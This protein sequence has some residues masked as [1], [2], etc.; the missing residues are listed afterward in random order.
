MRSF[1]AALLCQ[2]GW[3]SCA[4][5]AFAQADAPAQP[6]AVS[7]SR[8]VLVQPNADSTELAEAPTRIRAELEAAGFD[9]E[10]VDGDPSLGPREQLERIEQQS[11][12]GATPVA[13]IVLAG[14]GS[15]VAADI[16][17]ADRVTAKTTVR[18]I[19]IT[20]R[21]Q[22]ASIL[23]VR[24]VELLRASLLETQQPS[25]PA[26]AHDAATPEVTNRLEP[27][28][29]PPEPDASPDL[30]TAMDL[31]V[32]GLFGFSGI[33]P[34]VGPSLRVS[35][36]TP[37]IKGRVT[38][39]APILGE[40]MEQSQGVATA[41]PVLA[42]LDVVAGFPVDEK[43]RFYGSLG[44]GAY[45]LRVRGDADAPAIAHDETASGGVVQMGMGL[46]L[47]AS[48]QLALFIEPQLI[49]LLP[50]VIVRIAGQEA[51]RIGQ[52]AIGTT[53]GLTWTF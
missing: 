39:A 19:D 21:A 7:R 22:A 41:Q 2:L 5:P 3:A 9:V 30:E 12:P 48:P 38:L 33:R 14:T 49:W 18:R 11:A 35:V 10:I 13:T 4:C 26:E 36:G 45:L 6:A 34:Q 52:P 16:W 28:Q 50:E 53:I 1:A 20:Q 31:G 47:D 23:A 25:A 17:I 44:F 40:R 46:Q 24:T 51:A 15:G 8:V 37:N 43:L 42:Q 32:I 29:P 27:A